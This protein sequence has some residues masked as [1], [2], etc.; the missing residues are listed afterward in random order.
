MKFLILAFLSLT[1]QAADRPS[2]HGMLLFGKKNTMY[3]S[4]LPMFHNPHDYQLIATLVVPREAQAAYQKSLSEHPEETVYTLVPETFVLPEMVKS[5]RP[6]QASLVRGHFERGGT[7]FVAKVTVSFGRIVHFRKFEPKD[8]KPVN[9]TYLYFGSREEAFL[10][11]YITSKP[12]FDHVVEVK[13]SAPEMPW[14]LE[15][16][17][18]NAK[19]LGMGTQPFTLGSGGGPVTLDLTKTLYF[20]T[21]DLAQ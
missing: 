15:S 16:T 18:S 4:H 5:P 8:T 20:E 13:G 6:F 9:A 7:E 3:V 12:D 1:A 21:G 11:H 14:T 2:L 19:Q 17:Q 10:A